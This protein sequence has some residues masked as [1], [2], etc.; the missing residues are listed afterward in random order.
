MKAGVAEVTL[1]RH[2]GDKQKLFY[3]VAQQIG[4]GPSLDKLEEQLTYEIEVDLRL[5]CEHVLDFFL[6]QQNAIRML[7]FE[8]IHFPEMKDALAQN[9]H[10]MIKLLDRY[11]KKQIE[12]G[13]VQNIKPLAT[14]QTFMSMIFGYAIGMEP[15]KELLPGKISTDEVVEEIV[16]IF[17]AGIKASE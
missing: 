5:I 16:R 15:V 8:S 1:F 14:A 9:P 7:L 13:V 12:H 4:G 11:F 3:T 2:F 10:R 17:L 6:A